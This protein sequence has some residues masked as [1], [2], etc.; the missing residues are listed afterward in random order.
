MAFLSKFVKEDVLQSFVFDL[1]DSG[2]ELFPGNKVFGL[3]YTDNITL[4]SDETGN[5]KPI[6]AL[7]D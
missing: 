2:V 7:G 1:L 4:L 6:G 3:E 5:S